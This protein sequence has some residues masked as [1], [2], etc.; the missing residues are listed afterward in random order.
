MGIFTDLTPRDVAALIGSFFEIAGAIMMAN[1][2]LGAARVK[3]WMRLILSALVRGDEARG[4][5]QG[6]GV[7]E[8][9]GLLA[10]QGLALI[11]IGFLLQA[12]ALLFLPNT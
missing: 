2:Y 1:S 6:R 3:D 10:L 4:A 7:N 9:N 5:I 11:T 12:L 8:E